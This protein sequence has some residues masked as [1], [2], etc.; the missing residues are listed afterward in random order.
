[1]RVLVENMFTDV[2]CPWIDLPKNTW[3]SEVITNVATSVITKMEK[4]QLWQEQ[5]AQAKEQT[6]ASSNHID[7]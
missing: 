3:R 4:E 2:P 7:S 6:E 1:M 5:D